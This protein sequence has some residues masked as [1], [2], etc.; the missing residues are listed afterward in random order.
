MPKA[1]Q[2]HLSDRRFDKA[3]DETQAKGWTV[4]DLK[5]EWNRVFSF[6]KPGASSF[7]TIS[8]ILGIGERGMS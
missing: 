7:S 8:S 4:V 2:S 3:L 6:E 1:L 5:N